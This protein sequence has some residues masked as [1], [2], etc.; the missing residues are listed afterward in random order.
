MDCKEIQ[1]MIVP[2]HKRAL[3]IEYEELFADHIEQCPDCREELEIYYII[4]YGLSEEED[5]IVEDED[6][7]RLIE[8]F[9]F[10]GLVELKLGQSIKRIEG[11]KLYNKIM[12]AFVFVADIFIIVATIWWLFIQLGIEL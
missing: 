12:A 5:L 9:D 4:E 3:S 1:K 6:D 7:A 11:Y 2:F 10:K 8:Q